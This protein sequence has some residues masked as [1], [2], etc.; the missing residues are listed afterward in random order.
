[1]YVGDD[2]RDMQAARAAGMP[3]IAAAYGYLGGA[4]DLDAWEPDAVIATPADLPALL[5]TV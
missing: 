1:V 2:L 3:C 4:P 5:R